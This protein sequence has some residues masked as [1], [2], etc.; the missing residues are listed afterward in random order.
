MAYAV[1]WVEA[2]DARHEHL[3][4]WNRNLWMKVAPGRRFQWLYRD[5]PVGPGRLAVLE[6]LDD[7]GAS[8]GFVGTAGYGRRVFHDRGRVLRAAL[9]CDVAVDL[10][11]R[12]AMPAFMVTTEMRRHVLATFDLAYG[13]PNHLSEPLVVRGYKKLGHTR[14]F[15]L[16]VRHQ[17]YVKARVA[18][19]FAQPLTRTLLTGGAALA[20]DAAR[21]SL[22]VSRAAGPAIK[23]RLVWVSEDQVDERFDRLWQEASPEYSIIGA[24]DRAFVR[25]RFLSRAEGRLAVAALENRK[26]GAIAGYAAVEQEGDVWHVRDLFAHQAELP[27]LLRLLCLALLVKGAASISLRLL[28][29]PAVIDALDDLGFRERADKRTFVCGAGKNSQISAAELYDVAR[30]YITDADEDA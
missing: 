6:A 23:H 4:I 22:I 30:W 12:T 7:A 24:R 17:R 19:R 16:A 21:A 1:R 20:L 5:N 27:A 9:L 11:H 2:A 28:A 18:E 29:P 14:R 25:W 15:A 3:D 13:F 10:K 8:E 26:T